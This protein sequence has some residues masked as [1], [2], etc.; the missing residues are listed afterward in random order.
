LTGFTNSRRKTHSFAVAFWYLPARITY[1]FV[2]IAPLAMR[3]LFAPAYVVLRSLSIAY[4]IPKRTSPK[5]QMQW[6]NTGM[7]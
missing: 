6:Q 7:D 5:Y 1:I 3:Q 2:S 4:C